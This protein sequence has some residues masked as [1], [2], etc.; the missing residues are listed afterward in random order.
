MCTREAGQNKYRER[1][2]IREKE[3]E[4]NEQMAS[5]AL[6]CGEL[7]PEALVKGSSKMQGW[8]RAGEPKEGGGVDG[9][10]TN[11]D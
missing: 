6:I 10:P 8:S 1:V 3:T 9:Q 5:L 2:C 4:R 7:L 11:A